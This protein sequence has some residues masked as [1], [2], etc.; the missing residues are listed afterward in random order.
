MGYPI[1]KI[2]FIGNYLPRRCGIATFT[3]DLAETMAAEFPG[4]ECMTVAVNDTPAGYDYP[5]RVRFTIQQDDLDSYRSAAQFLNLHNVDLVC[6]QHEFGIFGGPAGSHILTLLHDLNIPIVTT[7]HTVLTNPTPEQ[8]RVMDELA[9]LSDRLIVM[10]QRAVGFLQEIYGLTPEK[11][12]LF[13]HGIPDIP[14]TETGPLKRKLELPDGHMLLTFGLLSP[15]KGLEYVLE[16]LPAVL[17][18]H[19]DTTYICLGATHPHIQEE[20][21]EQYRDSLKELAARLGIEKNVIFED[22]FVSQAELVDYIGA[23]DIY[24]TPYLNPAQIVSGTLAYTIGAGKAVVSTPYWYAEELLADGRG[25]LVPF[26]DSQA[27]A[28]AILSFMDDPDIYQRTRRKAYAFG[29]EMIWPRVARKY[30][31]TF[32]K[33]RLRYMEY[34][35]VEERAGV[36]STQPLAR[37]AS[38]LPPVNL[39]HLLRMTDSTG[40]L[41]HAIYDLPNYAEGYCTDDNARALVL[42][43]MLGRLDGDYYVDSRSLASRYLAFLWYAFND[44]K[45]R[46]HNFLGFDG[47]WLDEAGSEDSH[48]RALWALGEVLGG[49]ASKGTMAVAA[50][51]FEK[52]LPWAADASSPRTWAFSLLGISRYLQRFPGDRAALAI[53]EKLAGRLASLYKRTRRPGWNWFEDQLTY[54][55]ATLSHALLLA[56]AWYRDS[57]MI[58]MALES[59]AWLL[60]EQRSSSGYFVPIGSNGF[61]RRGEQ[62]A[63]FDQQPI[64]ASAT[65]SACLDA[66]RITGDDAWYDS[67]R[68]A[69]EWFL[70]RNDLGVPLYEAE[71]G[72]CHDGL[73]IDRLNENQ[74]AESTLAGLM[75]LTEMYLVEGL[76]PIPDHSRYHY[77]L[78]FNRRSSSE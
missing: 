34:S 38:D 46:F 9:Q 50:R 75:A 16:A 48:G 73:Q 51:L 44:R 58:D 45:G 77:S 30:L 36:H 31:E 21:G 24:I 2:A 42:A 5:D 66:F 49:D 43:I 63:R 12:D 19:P 8:R 72:G 15:N 25:L 33:A 29:R 61:Y 69:F 56:G 76:T 54:N 32:Q 78:L 52:A 39:R 65:V 3:F 41:Q 28:A 40:I 13:P 60:R 6:L 35:G 27:I 7:L 26:R 4:I 74:G 17:E 57:V 37:W 10:S 1:R 47:N 14:F 55:N 18:R 53:H 70:G 23:A 11:I 20:F 59:L 67:A 62:K 71:S 68:L 22:R 64:E